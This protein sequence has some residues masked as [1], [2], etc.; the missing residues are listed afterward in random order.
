M[1]ET[2]KIEAVIPRDFHRAAM[3]VCETFNVG[4]DEFIT[5]A[6]RGEL[7]CCENN[8]CED[9]TGGIVDNLVKRLKEIADF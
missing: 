2:V 7:Q 4:L 9:Y 3:L 1:V 5:N 8:N 6:V